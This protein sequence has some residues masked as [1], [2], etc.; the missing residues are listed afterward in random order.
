MVSP[1]HWPHARDRGDGTQGFVGQE[2]TPARP[3]A[4]ASLK[5]AVQICDG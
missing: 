4:L 5:Q 3:D 1:Q 2:F